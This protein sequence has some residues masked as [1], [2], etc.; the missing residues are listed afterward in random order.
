MCVYFQN[1]IKIELKNTAIILY[2]IFSTSYNMTDFAQTQIKLNVNEWVPSEIIVKP[3]KKNKSNAGAT[4]SI[5]S[6]QLN[7][8]LRVETPLMMTWGI[9]DYVDQTTGESDGKYTMS[10]N[11][12]NDEYATDE[13]RMLLE[14]VKGFEDHILD[15]A[16]ENSETW[17]GKKKTKELVE[18][19]FSSIIKTNSKQPD[20]PPSLRIKVPYYEGK[21][22]DIS[23]FDYSSQERLYP[24][25][26]DTITPPDLVPKLSQIACVIQC[27]GLWFVG[28]RWG[29]KWVLNQAVVKKKN[30]S[31]FQNDVCLIN[32]T[33]SDKKKMESFNVE[34]V[35][36]DNKEQDVNVADS[37]EEPEAV[38]PAPVE[39]VKPKKKVVKKKV[40]SASA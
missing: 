19:S 21:W 27:S 13:T 38:A 17:F 40:V 15:I 32:L 36:E 5:F 11:F 35:E 10:L 28:G 31:G 26:D 24:S 23:L 34:T 8:L 1:I 18:D 30:S 12:P 2:H 20:R 22:G 33:E 6:S 39:E 16:V 14:K 25:P 37:D 9:A 3:Y 4:A 7:K 29:V